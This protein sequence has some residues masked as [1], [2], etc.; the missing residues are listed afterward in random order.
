MTPGVYTVKLSV[1]ERDL[2]TKLTV[3]KD[4]KRPLRYAYR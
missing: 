1:D 3:R 4:P 2:T